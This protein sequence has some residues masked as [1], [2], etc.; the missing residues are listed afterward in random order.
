MSIEGRNLPTG[1]VT[2]LFTDIEGSTPL[3]EQV[4]TEMQLAVAQHHAI[5]RK[6]IEDNN[7][8]VF[9]ILG[10]AF[11][12]AFRLAGE[13]LNAA[14]QTQRQLLSAEWGTTGPLKVRIG[15]HTGPLELSAIPDQAGNRE[16]AVCHTLNRAA[17]VMSAGYGGQILISQETKTLIERELPED[18][19]LRDLGEHKL[20]GMQKLEHLYQAVAS[21]LPNDFPPLVTEI[22]HPHNLPVEVTSFI[23]REKEIGELKQLLCEPGNRLVTVT[24]FGGVGKTRLSLQVSRSLLEIYED[25]VW[26]VELA[27]LSDPSLVSQYIAQALRVREMPG[28][29]VMVT[30]QVYFS[31]KHLLLILDNCEHLTGAVADLANILLRSCPRLHILAT[32]R[33]ILGVDGEIPYQCPTLLNVPL[34]TPYSLVSLGVSGENITDAAI[35]LFVERAITSYPG[36]RLNKKDIVRVGEICRQLDGIPLA[37]ELAA[38][39]VRVLSVEQ[40]AIRLDNMFTLL[41]GGSRSMIS[42]H[43]TLKSL[44]D[45]SY[46][47]LSSPEKIMLQRL[48]VF[49]GGWDME[50]AEAI[51]AGDGI[52]KNQV[53]DLTAQLL[54]KSLIMLECLEGGDNRYRMLETI[55]Q[56]AYDKLQDSDGLKP[57]RKHHL[58]YFSHLTEQA[59]SQFWE[60]EQENWARR[61]TKEI[62]NLR[63]ALNWGLQR[64]AATP[65]EIDLAVRMATA[66]WI[67]WYGYGVIKEAI[68]WLSLAL[69]RS[70]HPNQARAR[71]LAAYGTIAWQLGNLTEA[72]SRLR[73][74]L[75]LYRGL[76]D[77]PG[78]AE[79]THMYGHVVFDQKK[80]GEAERVFKD[81]LSRYEAL[82]NIGVRVA[83]IGDLGLVACHRGKINLARQYYE[84]CL[85]L[86]VQHELKDNI[87]QSYLRLGDLSR[88]EGDYEGADS[89][90]Q[91]GLMLNRELR[92]SKEIAS[93]LHKLGFIALYRDDLNQAQ[94][95]FKESLVI[96]EDA[97]NQQG[98]AECLAGLASF[99]VRKGDDEQ[100]AYYFGAASEILT[101]TGLPLGPADV[102]EWRRDEAVVQKRCAPELFK[103]A[104]SKGR[105]L[106][107]DDLLAESSNSLL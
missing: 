27:S 99:M 90:Y 79:A 30:L 34:S 100:A 105:Q 13:A 37:I 22:I 55:R 53:V 15:L 83:L 59:A 63:S 51:V 60:K 62:D 84:Q 49:I 57:I 76:E 93:S 87:A 65:E 12:A 71:I 54:D 11:Q 88:L 75:E 72:A 4:P 74:S 10:D 41:T 24:G 20:K 47:L 50:A 42:H 101:R 68:G 96:Q 8:Q 91:K 92:L 14:I 67:Y 103:R 28:Q 73:A 19:S 1:T 48:S 80:Y 44:I 25:G 2:L 45:W 26:L 32:S 85:G 77:P 98:I 58:D 82:N 36:I 17:R 46:S 31:N 23:G 107:I 86:S 104:W 70:P 66:L 33:E 94:S 52:E 9:Q 64:E 38:A 40:I 56:Y 97:S 5:L 18:I 102:A 95:L 89:Y 35:R 21:E 39:R 16:Y 29:S 106:K 61:L 81:S 7:G 43:Q 6:V 78:L 3:W 69:E